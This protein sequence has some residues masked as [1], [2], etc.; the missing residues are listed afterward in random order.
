MIHTILALV[1][2]KNLKVQ[3]M[4]V[5]GTYLNRN[6]QKQVYMCQ[7]DGYS[8]GANHIC[9]LTKTLYRLKQAS[10]EQN[11]KL[12]RCVKSIG[13]CPL[14]SDPCAYVRKTQGNLQ[15]LTIWVD[16][17]LL[18]CT[19]QKGMDQLKANLNSILDLMD[20]GKP[21][22]IIGIKITCR[23]DSICIMQKNYIESILKQ[24][25]M[26]NC[27]PVKTPLDHHIVLIQNPIGEDSDH[28]NS[29]TSLIDSLQ[30][31]SI[32]IWPDITYAI[33]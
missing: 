18:F 1:P 3:Q 25:G 15:I 21:L 26:E 8:N 30:Y 28:S 13:F 20:I 29:F 24:E 33:N 9:H 14:E 32:A 7:P 17:I 27:H 22:K 23:P 6:L 31:L 12:D 11:K 16:N 10:C 4:D 19:T 2:V 5:K